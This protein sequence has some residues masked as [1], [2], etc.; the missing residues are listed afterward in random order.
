VNN[1]DW[2]SVSALV[3]VLVLFV[4]IFILRT[5]AKL[6]FTPTVLGAMAVGVAI[7]FIFS[8][9]TDWIR[10]IGNIY[11]SILTAIVAPLIIVSIISS[12]TSLG[13]AKQLKGIGA[14]SVFWLLV[15]TALSII[16]AFVLATVFNVGGNA[17]LVIDGV[18]AEAYENRV[19]S[20]SQVLVGF[21]PS[22]IVSDIAGNNIIPIILF[23]TLIAVS[24]VLVAQ[25]RRE[26]V[27]VFKHFIEALKEIVFKAVGFII[28]LTPYA[29]LALVAVSISG[30][31]ARS[32]TMISLGVLLLIAFV[33]FAI[34]VW[35][36]NSVLLTAFAKLNP[37]R[38]F[39]KIVPAQAVAFST[40]SSVGTLPVT[41]N[42]L[43]RRIGVGLEVTNFTA[44][45]GTTIGM[46]GCA[47][48]WP[49]LNAMYGIHG[50][51]IE[52]SASDYVM[53]GVICLF[54]S[55]GTAGVPGTA[56]VTT[57]SVLAAA[58]LPLEILVLVLPISAIAD[59]GRTATNVTAAIVASAIVGRQEKDL[60]DDIFNGLKEFDEEAGAGGADGAGLSGSGADGADLYGGAAAVQIEEEGAV[61]VGSCSIK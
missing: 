39:R 7:G 4:G 49:M 1:L 38:F 5:R 10:P 37:I 51:G 34:D 60:D 48:I 55:L 27:I 52:Y 20:F 15:T 44:P 22:N 12:V 23:S 28:E 36:I 3:T 30:S 57:A 56:T 21:F 11:V 46:P 35:L 53:L 40:Q 45:L 31:V 8:G 33:A 25:H 16:L 58:G 26:K 17:H 29:V 54:V 14:R 41:T 47:G 18:T 6:G 13:S 59:T 61:P 43:T 19:V 24:Y 2:T 9:H 50:L 42:V 32:S